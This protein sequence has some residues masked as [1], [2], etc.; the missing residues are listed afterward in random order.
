MNDETHVPIDPSQAPGK[1]TYRFDNP[2]NV[3][4]KET[5]MPKVKFSKSY[6]VWQA[7]DEEGNDCDD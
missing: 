4:I 2:D 7:I 3:P 6:L 5:I 1:H